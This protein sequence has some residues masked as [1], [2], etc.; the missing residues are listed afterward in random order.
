MK[1]DTG[2]YYYPVPANKKVK[3]Y[4]REEDGVIQFRLHNQD[5]PSVWERHGW[6]TLEAVR[7]AAAEYN[8]PVKPLDIYD[9]NVARRLLRE[10]DN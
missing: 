10:D 4:I 2:L 5:E 1:D 9:I 8:G 3:M 6:I 7:Q